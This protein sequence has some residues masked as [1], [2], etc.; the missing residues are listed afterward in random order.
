M[1]V[2]NLHNIVQ[3]G[4]EVTEEDIKKMLKHLKTQ[5]ALGKD[6]I[7]NEHLKYSGERLVELQLLI[8]KVVCYWI[9]PQDI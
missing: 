8:Q 9:V 1:L 4:I 2:Q 3:T 6:A 5:T 7:I